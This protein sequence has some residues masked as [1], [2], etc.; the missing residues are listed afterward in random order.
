[1]IDQIL[2]NPAIVAIISDLPTVVMLTIAVIVLWRDN[3]AL[4]DKLESVRQ[5]SAGNTA[6]LLDQNNEL[7][8]IKTH[9][10]GQTPPQGIY[11]VSRDKW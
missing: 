8:K 1:M 6:L 5:V 7:D 2:E 4:R 11:P 9:V 10:T 3:K